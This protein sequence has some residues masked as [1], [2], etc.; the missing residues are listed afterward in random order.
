MMHRATRGRSFV[1]DRIFRH[2]GRINRASGTAHPSTFRAISAMLTAFQD[3]GRRDLLE[4]V[5]DSKVLTPLD[6][7]IAYRDDRLAELPTAETGR[8]LKPAFDAWNARREASTDDKRGKTKAL[9]ILMEGQGPAMLIAQVPARLQ[10]LRGEREAAGT[11]RSFNLVREAV[12]A[13][14]AATLGAKHALY[15]AIRSVQPLSVK[16]KQLKRPQSPR[17]LER[18]TIQLKRADVAQMLWSIASTGMGSKEYWG[19]WE[20]TDDG[21]AIHGTKRG[22]RERLVPDLG[23]CA[24]PTVSR[25]RFRVLFDAERKRLGFVF[26]LYDLRRSFANWMEAAGIIRARRRL[27]L[28]HGKK[29]V[30][31]LYEWHEVQTFLRE[32]AERLS[33]WVTAQLA[34]SPKPH[35]R[36]LS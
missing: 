5:R 30:T 24:P 26:T 22:G 12:S 17:D 29:D 20:R 11:A 10:Q 36:K 1:I 31:D 18:V 2:V 25:H 9:R 28:G 35:L 19:R 13:F 34:A 23:R 7:Y 27:Y 33:A 32:D 16:A 3:T 21:I 6:V 4:L 15:L 8:P 14:A